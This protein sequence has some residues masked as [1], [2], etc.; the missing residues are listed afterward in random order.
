MEQK[1]LDE[2]DESYFGEE[3]VDEELIAG[4]NKPHPNSKSSNSNFKED[5][6]IKI[7]PVLSESKSKPKSIS[8]KTAKAV[9]LVKDAS[10]NKLSVDQKETTNNMFN[11][12]NLE[13]KEEKPAAANILYP[14]ELKTEQKNSDN[15]SGSKP[16]TDPFTTNSTADSKLSGNSTTWKAIT[17]IAVVL[18]IFSIFTQGF[19]FS[20]AATG[21]A[22]VG[23][24]ISLQQASERVIEY[25]NSQLLQPPYV[26]S[27]KNSKETSLFYQLTLDVAGQ[28]VV[29]Y[30]TKDGRL[31]FPQ[32]IDISG[33]LIIEPVN[34]QKTKDSGVASAE[35]SG[36]VDSSNLN[37]GISEPATE[38]LVTATPETAIA[39]DSTKITLTAKKWLFSPYQIKVKQGQTINLNIEPENL[40]FTFSISELGVEKEIK[41]ST[42]VV[43]NTDRK[44]VFQFTCSSCEEWRGMTGSLI[45]E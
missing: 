5:D 15:S 45:V 34:E 43:F 28:E 6:D 30:V 29:S 39:T 11:T 37:K 18:L 8:K 17:G 40:D 23:K 26:A 25:V 16:V 42:V 36:E 21:A 35:V 10:S 31:F 41:G 2:I 19:N 1:Q 12:A 33:Y 13:P 20:S 38:E 7:E 32:A 3:F 24:V 27:I 4:S 44:G 14:S 22:A 9:K